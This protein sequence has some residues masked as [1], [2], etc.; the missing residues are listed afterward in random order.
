MDETYEYAK[1]ITPRLDDA[2]ATPALI[3]RATIPR[4]AYRQDPLNFRTTSVLQPRIGSGSEL[5]LADALRWQFHRSFGRTT[6]RH[7]YNF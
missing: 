6:V 1:G 5:R 3:D 7:M 2:I 4:V